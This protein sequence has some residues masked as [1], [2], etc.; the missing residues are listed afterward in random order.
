MLPCIGKVGSTNLRRRNVFVISDFQ[1]CQC[2]VGRDIRRRATRSNCRYGRNHIG[3]DTCRRKAQKRSAPDVHFTNLAHFDSP[4]VPKHGNSL[5]YHNMP[6][7]L[8]TNVT[9]NQSTEQRIGRKLAPSSGWSIPAILTK[10]KPDGHASNGS[11]T[12]CSANDA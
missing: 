1:L 11:P 2:L 5:V 4:L 7:F 6:E 12:Y 3:H 9:I 8:S 10:E